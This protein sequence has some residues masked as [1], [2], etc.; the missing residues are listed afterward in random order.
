[1]DNHHKDIQM[2]EMYIMNQN[3]EV[4]L[5]VLIAQKIIPLAVS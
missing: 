4:R 1:M 2:K 3:E 5:M